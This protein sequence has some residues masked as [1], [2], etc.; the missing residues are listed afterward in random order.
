MTNLKITTK[1]VNLN[2]MRF[3][4]QIN[5]CIA[6]THPSKNKEKSK[7]KWQKLKAVLVWDEGAATCFY[8]KRLFNS[9]HMTSWDRHATSR[10]AFACSNQKLLS[11]KKKE[12]KMKSLSRRSNTKYHVKLGGGGITGCYKDVFQPS[13]STGLKFEEVDLALYY[14]SICH[15]VSVSLCVS[16]QTTE[17]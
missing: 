12:K 10:L 16:C 13:I 4:R 6:Q 14:I 11:Q 2:L 7:D 17:L 15:T 1:D 5:S 8:K 3:R 9:L